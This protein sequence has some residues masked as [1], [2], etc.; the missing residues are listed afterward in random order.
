MYLVQGQVFRFSKMF[1]YV[2]KHFA[3]ALTQKLRVKICFRE[4]NYVLGTILKLAYL[5]KVVYRLKCLRKPSKF[6]EKTRIMIL[7][8]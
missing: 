6:K 7:K 2:R 5:S 4:N 1:F 3:C 8:M